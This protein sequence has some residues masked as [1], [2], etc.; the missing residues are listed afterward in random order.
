MLT[1]GQENDLEK[2]Q[3]K[4]LRCMYGYKK[5][6]TELLE[7]SGL[8]PLKTRRQSAVLKFARKASE[9]PIYARWF[10]KNPN[11]TSTRN[12]TIFAE[13]FA[14]TNHLYNSPLYAMR[15]LLNNTPYDPKPE[16]GVL[17]LAYLFDDI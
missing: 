1:K 12:P 5:L 13:S 7:E 17:D 8:Q 4:A 9:N 10:K 11:L 6:Y 15:R 3:K 14:R 16:S 2:V